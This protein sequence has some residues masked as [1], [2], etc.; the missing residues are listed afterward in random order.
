MCAAP[1]TT[2]QGRVSGFL[3]CLSGVFLAAK[4][5]ETAATAIT[6]TK[7][8]IEAHESLWPHGDGIIDELFPQ[9]KSGNAS[10]E[11]GHTRRSHFFTVG[12]DKQPNF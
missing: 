3:L 4:E 9:G 11:K 5:G 8:R 1:F 6:N 7:K 2:N 12:H 10:R